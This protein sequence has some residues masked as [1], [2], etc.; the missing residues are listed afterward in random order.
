L[1]A[2][3]L[4]NIEEGKETGVD[5]TKRLF[6]VACS[7]AKE[8]LAIVAYSENP[9]IVQENA[10]KYGWFEKNEIEIIN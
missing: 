7:R 3:D 6:Y 4:K 10:L 5:R 9:S 1:S 8:G 2:N